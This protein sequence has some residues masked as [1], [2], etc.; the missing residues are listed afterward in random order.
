MSPDRMSYREVLQ[1]LHLLLDRVGETHWRDWIAQD[2][3]DWDTQRSVAH[4]LSAYGGMGSLNDVYFS[5]REYAIP[6]GKEPWVQALFED[7]RSISSTLANSPHIFAPIET[8]LIRLSIWQPRLR[9]QGWKCRSCGYADVSPH[10]IETY[11][12]RRESK[13]AILKALKESNLSQLVQSV[14]SP[15]LGFETA[16]DRLVQQIR[17]SAIAIATREGWMRPCPVCGGGD[18]EVTY[19]TSRDDRFVPA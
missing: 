10:E 6:P 14:L 9:L 15:T 8:W 1:A 18:T 2:L 16:R 7:L 5:P 4:H 13:P 11:L 12:A 3:S 17:A 19:W